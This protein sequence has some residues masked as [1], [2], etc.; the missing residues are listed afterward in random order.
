VLDL[1]PADEPDCGSRRSRFVL[2]FQCHLGSS[3]ST[4]VLCKCNRCANLKSFT[5]R[6][7]Q[8]NRRP[9]PRPSPKLRRAP[10]LYA[11]HTQCRSKA[12]DLR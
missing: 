6:K 10:Q 1:H 5:W 9:N 11:L 3:F 7:S 12:T 8:L 4:Y 2:D